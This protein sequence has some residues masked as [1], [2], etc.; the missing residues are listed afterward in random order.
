VVVA[1]F[2]TAEFCLVDWLGIHGWPWAFYLYGI[3]FIMD[4]FSYFL[5][6]FLIFWTEY[7]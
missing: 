6:I 3:S 1:M 5:V 7:A 2:L 4:I